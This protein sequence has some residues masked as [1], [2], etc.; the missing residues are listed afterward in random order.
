MGIPDEDVARVRAS[1]DIVALIGEH[2]A[3]KRV[4]RRWSR[5]VPVSRREDGVVQ[6]Q[7]RRGLLLLLRLPGQR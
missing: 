5:P 6:R 4:G 3:L 7:R 1:T 2:V